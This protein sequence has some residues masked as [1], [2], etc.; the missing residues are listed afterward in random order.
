MKINIVLGSNFSFIDA[1]V[2][3]D[4]TTLPSAVSNVTS[5]E[6]VTSTSTSISDALAIVDEVD[7]ISDIDENAEMQK[8]K[9]F[10]KE[11]WQINLAWRFA[12]CI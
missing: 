4:N 2:T 7:Q 1:N 6:D 5:N 9:N 10:V 3:E 12:V 8:L 11:I